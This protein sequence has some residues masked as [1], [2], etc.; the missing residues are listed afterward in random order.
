VRVCMSPLVQIWVVDSAGVSARRGARE[1]RGS[2]EAG[3]A[4]AGGL[5][6]VAETREPLAVRAGKV[7][8]GGLTGQ[9]AGQ[10]AGGEGGRADS[11][12][13][14]GSP[15]QRRL[16]SVPLAV[17][18]SATLNGG[19]ACASAPLAVQEMAVRW[20]LGSV[21]VVCFAAEQGLPGKEAC[22][23]GDRVVIFDAPE[24]SMLS[25]EA[26]ALEQVS[27]VCWCECLFATRARMSACVR[28]TRDALGPDA[29]VR[30]QTCACLIC[31]WL[32]GS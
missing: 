16:L 27:V 29:C 19:N 6:V 26:L 20:G 5:W 10:S 25:D 9:G 14:Q 13:C 12:A 30:Y 32:C 18:S 31:V 22:D 2:Q 11:R 21:L 4:Q 3:G 8:K 17:L 28:V 24:L 23:L 15:G 7:E 1:A